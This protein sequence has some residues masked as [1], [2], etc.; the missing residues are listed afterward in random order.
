LFTSNYYLKYQN[1]PDFDFF[2]ILGFILQY[3]IYNKTCQRWIVI[4]TK[5]CLPYCISW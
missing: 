3:M 5:K 1:L 4:F 2:L